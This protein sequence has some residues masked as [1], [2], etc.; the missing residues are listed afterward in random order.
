MCMEFYVHLVNLHRLFPVYK[1]H[2]HLTNG[3]GK[4]RE[5]EKHFFGFSVHVH[6]DLVLMRSSRNAYANGI[7]CIN[8]QTARKFP[9]L[10]NWLAL[11][12]LRNANVIALL[13]V[14]QS[15]YFS[16]CWKIPAYFLD[17]A[18]EYDIAEELVSNNA[19]NANKWNSF[20]W[21]N[22]SIPSIS[23]D[24][25]FLIESDSSSFQ[26]EFS[27]LKKSAEHHL[28]QKLIIMFLKRN[29]KKVM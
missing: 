4:G 29:L 2:A 21:M 10:N 27:K 7:C 18:V 23:T 20:V 6:V 17:S 12:Y 24:Y 26:W 5:R 19:Q 22:L 8:E 1:I 14:M 28:R 25:N 16:C 13:N 9:T 15:V 3:N 11:D